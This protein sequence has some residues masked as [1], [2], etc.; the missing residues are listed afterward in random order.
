MPIVS[1]AAWDAVEGSEAVQDEVVLVPRMAGAANWSLDGASPVRLASALVSHLSQEG[2]EKTGVTMD[3]SRNRQV[4]FAE[5]WTISRDD[6][7][8]HAMVNP[9]ACASRQCS[10]LAHSQ[11]LDS[12]SA[13]QAR[14]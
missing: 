8:D 14:V 13:E 2:W 11:P 3:Q 4:G 12:S 6:P 1:V 9:R 7:G 10:R 5:Y